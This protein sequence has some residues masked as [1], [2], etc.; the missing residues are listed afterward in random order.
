M[1]AG[2]DQ[3][4]IGVEPRWEIL[5]IEHEVVGVVDRH[6]T[7]LG[8]LGDGIDDVWKCRNAIKN[9]VVDLHEIEH[10]LV[11][12]FGVVVDRDLVAGR[13]ELLGALVDPVEA[14]LRQ[15]T[16]GVDRDA[17][18]RARTDRRPL[19]PRGE[20]S[21]GPVTSARPCRSPRPGPG[22]RSSPRRRRRNFSWAS[23][24]W[25]RRRHRPGISSG[26]HH[27]AQGGLRLAERD[28]TIGQLAEGPLR[29]GI[30]REDVA[31]QTGRQGEVAAA[32]DQVRPTIGAR[33]WPG[34]WTRARA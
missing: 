29:A 20:G 16:I 2:V 9:R 26:R 23:R 1:L 3:A 4:G 27:G 18:D 28:L 34:A 17:A 5:R 13:H 8:R 11:V 19:L 15:A 33:G 21:R 31:A 25:R 12:I 14:A 30:E 6:D 10:V 7:E 22:R 24:R 32:L